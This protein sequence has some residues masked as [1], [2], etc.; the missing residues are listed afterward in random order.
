MA[1]PNGCAHCQSPD[2]EAEL[3]RWRCL[4]CGGWTDEHSNA[5]PRDPE[6]KV[7][8]RGTTVQRGA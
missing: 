6:F 8:Q 4:S 3:D 7:P 5:L 2:I 1:R